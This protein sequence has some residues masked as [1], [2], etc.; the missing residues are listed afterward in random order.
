MGPTFPFITP[1]M[2]HFLLL[3]ANVLYA[4]SLSV[5]LL[6]GR[7]VRKSGHFR[8]AMVRSDKIGFDNASWISGGTLLRRSLSDLQLEARPKDIANVTVFASGVGCFRVQ[9]DG[10]NVASSFLDPGWHTLPTMR[11]PYRAFDITRFFLRP[12]VP[13]NIEVSLGMCKYGYQNSFCKGAHVL[14][15]YAKLSLC[16]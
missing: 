6:D 13:R 3:D 5:T 2:E 8:T 4:L 15:M 11:I 14:Q 9:I 10:E 1:L 12:K 16:R 7:E